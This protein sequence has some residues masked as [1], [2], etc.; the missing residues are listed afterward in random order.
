MIYIISFL[1]V[2][3]IGLIG[4]LGP[5]TALSY[6][7][8]FLV[9]AAPLMKLFGTNISIPGLSENKHNIKDIYHGDN[10]ED[11]DNV[12]DQN[13]A[14]RENQAGEKPSSSKGEEICRNYLEERYGKPFPNT[15]PQW[16]TNPKTGRC[17]ELDCYNEELKI[18]VEYNGEQHYVFPNVWHK[19]KDVFE[20]QVRRDAHKIKRCKEYGVHLVVV[21]YTVK[22]CDIPKYIE[23]RLKNV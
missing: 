9:I 23:S 6:F 5:V 20:E 16:L 1:V 11:K 19:S 4:Y 17:L 10:V 18:A 21:P 3:L 2:A 12:E 7:S 15:R 13:K 8:A 14:K 22:K